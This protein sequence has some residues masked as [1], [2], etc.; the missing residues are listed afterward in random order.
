MNIDVELSRQTAS[1]EGPRFKRRRLEQECTAQGPAANN[2]DGETDHATG[3]SPESTALVA[4]M[5]DVCFGMVSFGLRTDIIFNLYL[6]TF[7]DQNRG[8][9]LKAGCFGR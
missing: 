8:K 4:H 2:C 3:I 9:K 6:L 7:E 1:M 5:H